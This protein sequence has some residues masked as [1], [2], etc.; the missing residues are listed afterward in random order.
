MRK[1]S[2]ILLGTLGAAMLL[3]AAVNDASATRLAVSI[4]LMRT[5]W[6]AMVFASAEVGVSVSCR[7]TLEGSF[8]SRTITKTLGTLMARYRRGF[9]GESTC[10]GGRARILT[11]SLPWHVRYAFFTGTLPNVTVWGWQ[12]PDW[13]FLILSR[14]FGAEVSCLYV[15]SETEPIRASV[16]REAGGAATSITL[17]GEIRSS[18]GGVCPRASVSGTSNRPTVEGGS[19]PITIT[20]VA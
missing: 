2:T 18:T 16:N 8:A 12:F 17:S 13:H 3:A 19:E 6:P 9:F 1:R 20:L 10:T 4:Q 7:V 14:V 15:T 11:E 5:V